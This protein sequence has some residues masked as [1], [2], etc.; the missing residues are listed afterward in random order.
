MSS[1]E[2]LSTNGQMLPTK[3]EMMIN[4]AKPGT[5]VVVD[6]EETQEIQKLC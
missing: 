3:Q 4:V 5:Q 6:A 2:D 1:V